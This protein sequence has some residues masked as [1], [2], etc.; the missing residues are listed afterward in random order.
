[1]FLS[2]RSVR[3]EGRQPL[4]LLSFP[5][6]TLPWGQDQRDNENIHTDDGLGV[7][8]ARGA[9]AELAQVIFRLLGEG[10]ESCFGSLILS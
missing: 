10:V 8:G 9:E 3:A 2:I 1:M 4:A 6:V 7:V 5:F